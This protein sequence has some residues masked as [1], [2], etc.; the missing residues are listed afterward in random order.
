[1]SRYEE[2]KQAI[3][4]AG[5]AFLKSAPSSVHIV[6][7]HDTDGLC[8]TAILEEALERK[9][10]S[11]TSNNYQHLNESTVRE[12]A[13]ESADIIIFAD[14]G[15]V[16]EDLIAS[17]LQDKTIFILD[18]HAPLEVSTAEKKEYQTMTHLNPHLYEITETNEISGSGIAYWFVL[19]MDQKN[20][21]L[22]GL[23][24]LGAIGDSQEKQ[25][26]RELNNEILQHAIL[27][28]SIKV[29]KRLKLHGINS[30]PLIKVL[31]YSSDL[32]IPG[33]TNDPEGV[34]R[35]LSDL[36]IRYTFRNGRLKKYYHLHPEQQQRLT[37]HI[38]YLKGGDSVLEESITPSY[39]FINETKRQ[40]LDLKEYAT[41]I[42][43]CGR[44][45]EYSTA[46]QALRGN[47]SAKD[48][49]IMNLRVYK[50]TL[51]EAL[52][53]IKDKKER[54]E[55]IQTPSLLLIDFEDQVKSSI[56]GVIASMTVRNKIVD[57]NTVVC[58]MAKSDGDSVKL[59]LRMGL[60]QPQE[61]L[62][63]I[64]QSIVAQYDVQAGGHPNAA[65]AVIP[66]EH[67]NDFIERLKT[68]FN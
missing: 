1:M 22:A 23:G 10:L 8:S 25:G 18:H 30:R 34:K 56:V 14:I 17:I 68:T 58:T 20:R 12:I 41:I 65:G 32:D 64:L 60:S 57:E 4:Q 40:C 9:S 37:D 61:R 27:Q 49:A 44:L 39:T 5:N 48:K 66:A 33:V 59:S 43:A 11:Y 38:I 47:D 53:T 62:D 2:F 29:G 51:R 7:H 67:K 26:F 36:R 55:L 50:N 42:N 16:N 6:A 13:K 52:H 28:Q 21:D 35:L 63:T 24:V 54:D 19:G 31:E 15:S 3:L 45:E 46:I